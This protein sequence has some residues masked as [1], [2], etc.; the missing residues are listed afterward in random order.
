MV[1]EATQISKSPFFGEGFLEDHAGRIISEPQLAITELVANCWDAGAKNVE[2]MWPDEV[3]G[4]FSINDNGTGMEKGEFESIWLELSYSRIQRLGISV[5]FPDISDNSKRTAYGRNGKGRHGLF[6]FTDQYCVETWKN[7]K[8]SFFKVKRNYEGNSARISP[9]TIQ[10]MNELAKEGHGTRIFGNIIKNYISYE[11]IQDVIGGKFATDPAFS[12]SLNGHKMMLLDLKGANRKTI[13]IPGEGIIEIIMLD[14]TVTGRT[15]KQHGIAWWV[16]HR[17]V[18]EHSWK[19]LNE[20]ILDRRTS[21]AKRF[22]FIVIAD[23]LIDE[24]KPDWT[25]FRE[26]DRAKKIRVAVNS[27]IAESIQ[28]LLKSARISRKKEILFE[29]KKEIKQLSNLSKDQIGF[30]IEQTL[31]KCPTLSSDNLSKVVGILTKIEASSTGYEFLHQLAQLSTSDFD[32]LSLILKDWSMVEVKT[33]LDELR[34][35]I[36]L[37][38]QME[39]LVGNPSTDELH[40]LHPLFERG[41]WIFGPEYEGI[42]YISNKTLA[43][44]IKE[45]SGKE[46]AESSRKR[47]D[48]VALA[49]ASIGTYSSD[50]YDSDGEICGYSKILIIELKRGGSIITDREAF[51]A[52]QYAVAIEKSGIS[53]SGAKIVCYVLG[54]KTDC[55]PITRGTTIEVIP[56]P[57]SIVLRRARARMFNLIDRI[58]EAKDI[59]EISDNEVKEVL[60]QRE[61]TDEYTAKAEGSA[62]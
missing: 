52:Q 16:N 30:F 22:T 31:I 18:G 45:F 13:N 42:K 2:I 59:E 7:G 8:S 27:Y 53:S 43:T 23:L 34:W 24:V 57:Y 19:G 44:I 33:I 62:I 37:I 25:D 21:E 3:N 1:V 47:P 40:E 55:E 50:N 54:T 41:L 36:E 6:C 12:I 10:F 46:V 56:I 20:P 26:S 58:K 9:Y 39:P 17:L 14:S 49:D 32:K 48:L 38:N 15:S 35:R 4:Q 51:Q 11:T 60:S 5:N 61:V 29:H 28:E